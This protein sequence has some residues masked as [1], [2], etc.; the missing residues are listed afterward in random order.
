MTT[1]LLAAEGPRDARVIPAV[2]QAS[3]PNATL[4][5]VPPEA[6]PHGPSYLQNSS[7]SAVV[8]RRRVRVPHGKFANEGEK[9]GATQAL[10]IAAIAHDLRKKEE[11][12][13][14]VLIV[15][16]DADRRGDSGARLAG[17]E[18]GLK[19]AHQARLLE[20]ITAIASV[21]TRSIEAWLLVGLQG[22]E[23]EEREK[24]DPT[25]QPAQLNPDDAKAAVERRLDSRD[26]PTEAEAATKAVE[27]C[28]DAPAAIK[29]TGLPA[30]LEQLREKL[31]HLT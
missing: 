29:E 26:A 16:M 17:L 25:R 9:P 14:A 11:P 31:A 30:F 13:L 7:W 2:V 21:P 28:E 19:A 4:N 6:R 8:R 24:V 18:Q 23:V 1:L 12:E 5:W 15:T 22:V 20:G 3:L 27:R 10:S